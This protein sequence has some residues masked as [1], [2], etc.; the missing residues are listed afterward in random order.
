MQPNEVEAPE[1]QGFLR[2]LKNVY[3]PDE[4][5][6]LIDMA[7][8]EGFVQASL[9]TDILGNEHYSDTRKS[10]RCIIDS[11]TFATDLCNRIR[12]FIPDHMSGKPFVGINE[13]LRILK[14]LPGD[15][16][17]PHVDGKYVSPSG[18]ISQITILIYLNHGYRGGY[19]CFHGDTWIPIEPDTGMV[20]LQD[21]DLL[22]GVP[23]L[24]EGIKYAIRTEVMYQMPVTEGPY[25][26]ITI[27][28]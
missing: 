13:R 5:K 9:Y 2:I 22:H 17:K 8:T 19:T 12:S 20:V 21:Q 7:E 26:D 16:F 1:I 10:Q 3:S 18:A 14:Y 4:C 23:P 25:K 24:E 6:A 27:T 11:E 15:E 28:L